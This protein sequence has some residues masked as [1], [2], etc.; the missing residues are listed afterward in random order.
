MAFPGWGAIPGLLDLREGIGGSLVWMG[1]ALFM[2]EISGSVVVYFFRNYVQNALNEACVDE[3]CAERHVS[4]VF[5]LF[6]VSFD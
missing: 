2:P 4:R 3:M 1:F 5:V 6:E